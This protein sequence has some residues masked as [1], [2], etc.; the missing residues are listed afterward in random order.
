MKKSGVVFS[1]LGAVV[2]LFTLGCIGIGGDGNITERSHDP[3]DV[4][5]LLLSNNWQVTLQTGA[6]RNECI[7]VTDE[8]LQDKLYIVNS[9]GSLHVRFEDN[10]RPSRTPQL[11][12]FLKKMPGSFILTGRSSV[13]VAG[14]VSRATDWRLSGSSKVKLGELDAPKLEVTS[15]GSTDFSCGG[16]VRE[17][18]FRLSGNSRLTCE[19]TI[20]ELSIIQ[21]GSAKIEVADCKKAELR[22]SGSSSIRIGVSEKADITAGSDSRIHITANG[23]TQILYEGSPHLSVTAPSSVRVYQK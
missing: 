21:S 4:S 16:N 8:N 11:R 10:A 9:A 1:L 15:S 6:E 23:D 14:K 3:G 22:L 19:G 18:D 7:V 2:W 13:E 5:S 20:G 17:A 12:L